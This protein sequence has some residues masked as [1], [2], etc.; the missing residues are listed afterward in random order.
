MCYPQATRDKNHV[1]E[2]QAQLCMSA[3]TTKAESAFCDE[4]HAQGRPFSLRSSLSKAMHELGAVWV[5]KELLHVS[6]K[7]EL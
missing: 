4:T 7:K 3:M 1:Q 5:E 6:R 2:P